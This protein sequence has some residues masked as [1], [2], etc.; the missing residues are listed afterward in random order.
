MKRF[1]VIA[2]ILAAAGAFSCGQ[3]TITVSPPL[4]VT[5]T[6]PANGA[7]TSSSALNVIAV[8]FSE[9]IDKETLTGRVS[10][11]AVPSCLWTDTCGGTPVS[12]SLSAVSEDK[13]TAIFSI[14][15]AL[16]PAMY[17]R[18]RVSKDGLKSESGNT[19][20]ADVSHY[21]LTE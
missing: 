15:A 10:L 7:T 4:F 13:L 8:T 14:G 20:A 5:D 9:V 3:S 1:F 21:F 16:A 19:M 18:I 2:A 12:I 11:A 17:Y 6:V